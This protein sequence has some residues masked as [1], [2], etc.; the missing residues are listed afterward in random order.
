[1][2]TFSNVTFSFLLTIPSTLPHLK[3]TI[4]KKKISKKISLI[5]PTP[6]QGW[7]VLV[8]SPQFTLPTKKLTRLIFTRIWSFT[9]QSREVT[10]PSKPRKFQALGNLRKHNLHLS[11]FGH[12]KGP[13]TPQGTS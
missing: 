10:A 7:K 1:M 5:I 3:V 8:T 2:K 11:S 13:N 6:I 9:M 12:P 4:L